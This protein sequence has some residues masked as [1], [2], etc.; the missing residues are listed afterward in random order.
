MKK[1]TLS[2]CCIL[3]AF[4][5][6]FTHITG[7]A[8]NLSLP[9]FVIYVKPPSQNVQ[10]GVNTS[11]GVELQGNSK[12]LSGNV[13]SY[14]T[15]STSGPVNIYGGVHRAGTIN[16]ALNNL[17]KGDITSAAN[18]CDFSKNAFVAGNGFSLQG[19]L[20]V[21][22]N[23]TISKYYNSVVNGKV[24]HPV[25]T[26]YKGPLPSQGEVTGK[27]SIPTLPANAPVT[28]FKAAGTTNIT[29]NKTIT[30]GAY[31]DIKLDG[32]KTITFS[33]PGVYIFSSIANTGDYNKFVFD[34]KNNTSGV[35]QLQVHGDVDLGRIQAMLKNGGDASRIYAE[36]HG[37]GKSCRYGV[38]AWSMDN[39]PADTA[40]WQ[41][42][43][44]A[45]YGGI[46]IGASAGNG[47]IVGALWSG[48]KITI[49]SGVQ[50]QLSPYQTC[51]PPDADAGDDRV[52]SCIDSSTVILN[53]SST[54]PDVQYSWKTIDTGFIVSG[55]NTP[56]PVVSKGGTYV[57]TVSTSGGC[58]ATD[59][60]IVTSS[61]IVPYYPPPDGGKTHD[62]IGSELNALY[63]NGNTVQ[64]TAQNVFTL[65]GDS[66][67]IE[68]IADNG[69]YGQLLS[70]LQTPEYGLTDVVNNGA[71]SLIITG[72]YPVANLLKLD[73][74][75]EL[76]NYCRPAFPPVSNTGIVNSAGDTALYSNFVRNGFNVSG[77]G[78]KVGVISNSFNTIRGNNALT[79]VLNGDLPGLQNPDDSTPVDILREYPYGQST[80]EGRAM[81]QIV[82]D[83]APKAKLAFRTGF[84]SAGDFAE[85]VRALKVD[86]CNII[87]DDVTYITE[88]FFKD[89]VV[90]KAVDEVTAGSVSY[91]TAAGNY[92]NKSYASAFNPVAA[93]S[94][95]NGF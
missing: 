34:F 66:V 56:N 74:L 22:G 30:P 73:S 64:D 53:G 76:I 51:T 94:G 92:G 15:I 78:I 26:Y 81:L 91:F 60:V 20:D 83:I 55:N 52:I 32:S 61:C 27:P 42:T 40:R 86:S 2:G 12:I 90:A 57:L 70:L 75:P 41:G 77:D 62:L 67:M 35:F 54:T 69:K 82:H 65:L 48:T 11:Y 46:N 36:T 19:N 33:G 43:V 71:N 31:K 93:P 49:G 88:P 50:V 87:V 47:N 3:F 10:Q 24:T 7:S 4:F 5:S 16:L 14:Y 28:G 58:S 79:D 38:Y 84:I 9:S 68:V 6:L 18:N 13:G 17:I 29:T 89:G 21:N 25:G 59:T 45:P 44:Y 23:I 72:K 95:F 39:C 37:D 80:D 63:D 8:Q 1:F 85:G